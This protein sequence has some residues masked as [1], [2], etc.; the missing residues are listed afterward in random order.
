MPSDMTVLNAANLCPSPRHV[1]DTVRSGTERLDRAPV[2]SFRDE[3]FGAKEWVR[4]RVAAYLRATPEEILITRN[5]SESNNW[6]SAGLTLGPGDE[7]LIHADN[8][9]SNNAAWKSRATRYGFTVREVID[10]AALYAAL[11][12]NRIRGGILDVWY[13]YP[14]KEDP[15]PWPSRF[16]FQKLDNVILSPHNSAWTEEM[17][18]RRWTFVASQLD[19]FARGETLRNVCFEGQ[20]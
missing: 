10:E 7:V 4:E 3:S 12:D 8:H 16:P 1:L 14:S 19:R 13:V 11:A 2:P 6:I 18:T 20:G 15:N 17:S 5:T 9:P